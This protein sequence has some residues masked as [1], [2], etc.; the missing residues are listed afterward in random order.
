MIEEMVQND[1][2]FARY[3]PNLEKISINDDR[4]V[5]KDHIKNRIIE[6]IAQR[7]ELFCNLCN[8]K[9]CIHI[10]FVVSLPEVYE[11]LKTKDILYN[12]VV[13]PITTSRIKI[14]KDRISFDPEKMELNRGY[15]FRLEQERFAFVRTSRDPTKIMLLT[16][17]ED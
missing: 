14:S 1:K 4:V 6:V 3:V 16:Q 10:K 9:D 13:N 5:L 8:E 15:E 17:V 12:E 11:I 2:V 7:G